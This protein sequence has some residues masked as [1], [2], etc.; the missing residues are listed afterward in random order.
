M[1]WILSES[2]TV[3]IVARE[4]RQSATRRHLI[5][6]HGT[7]S[8]VAFSHRQSEQSP[9]ECSSTNF[10][11]DLGHLK[12][13]SL[14]RSHMMR[15]NCGGQ[16]NLCPQCS[17]S[18]LET[19]LHM[20]ERWVVR[21]SSECMLITLSLFKEKSVLRSHFGTMVEAR[22]N[23]NLGGS[24]MFKARSSPW[25]SFLCCLGRNPFN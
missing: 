12:P 7:L 1:I 10:H 15:A 13:V 9:I 11:V 14:T 4:Q 21:Y 18:S 16:G 5:F 25:G 2:T 17:Y 6:L 3:V 23:L 22:D 19:S 20:V 8:P 24:R